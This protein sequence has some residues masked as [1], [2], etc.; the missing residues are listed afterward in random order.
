MHLLAIATLV[1]VST[2]AAAPAT[3][4]A[5][6][7]RPSIPPGLIEVEG[8][9]LGVAVLERRERVDVLL[10]RGRHVERFRIEGRS[11]VRSGSFRAPANARP[12]RL[13]AT[14]SADGDDPLVAVVFGEDLRS[15]DQGADTRL[16]AF[17]LAAREDGELRPVSEDLGAWL[18]LAGGEAYLQA[19]G[20]DE[21]A[22][23]PVRRIEETSGR[24]AA[25]AGEIPWAGRWLLD[26][27]PLPGGSDALAW[28]DERLHV[29]RLEG[30]DRVPGGSMLG[31]LGRVDEPRVAIRTDRPIMK[32]L[33]QEGRRKDQWRPVAR[34]VLVSGGAAYTVAR[35]RSNRLFG[36]A[37]GQ[38]AVVRLEW[39]GGALAVSRPYPAVDAYVLDFALLERPGTGPAALLLVNEKEDGSGRAHLL[40]QLPREDHRP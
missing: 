33:D 30:R 5:D 8:H 14:S 27:T 12:L 32:G 10:L 1:A 29:V 15:V 13:D 37:T 18:R 19:R 24:Y 16:H 31:D 21:L 26:A 23:G 6:A 3:G 7:P 40:F 22:S 4:A 17:L 20:T 9:P 34:R 28:D 35:E 36:K 38:D 2:N 25:G 11:L 39:S